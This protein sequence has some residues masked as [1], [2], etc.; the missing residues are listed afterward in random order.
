MHSLPSFGDTVAIATSNVRTS[1]DLS[2]DLGVAVPLWM[3]FSN[4][5]VDYL[6]AR[7]HERPR[8]AKPRGAA[9]DRLDRPPALGR[10]LT[11]RPAAVRCSYHFD[12]LLG[13]WLAD[14]TVMLR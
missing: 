2:G 12:L 10:D 11:C 1:T 8:Q 5:L 3:Q 14:H 7:K 9:I 4:G 6:I 13:E